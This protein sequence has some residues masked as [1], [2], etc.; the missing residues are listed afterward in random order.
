MC[1][2][3]MHRTKGRHI[4]RSICTTFTKRNN[5]VDLDIGATV[6]PSEWLDRAATNLASKI[7][8]D[9]SDC[10]DN[11]TPAYPCLWRI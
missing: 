11:L 1:L 7:R 6:Q 10:N 9:F 8:T 5:V 4:F 2:S 3:V